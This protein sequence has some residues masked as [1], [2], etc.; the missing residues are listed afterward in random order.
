MQTSVLGGNRTLGSPV[1][2]DVFECPIGGIEVDFD[3][4]A[5]AVRDTRHV[6]GVANPSPLP[7]GQ[8]QRVIVGLQDG[9]VN[10]LHPTMFAKGV[11]AGVLFQWPCAIGESD[12]P[13]DLVHVRFPLALFGR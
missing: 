5:S 3:D 2:L 13:F 10:R 12:R 7:S 8:V 6:T 9:R 4:L 11:I 1:A